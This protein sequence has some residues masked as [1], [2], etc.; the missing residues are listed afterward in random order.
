MVCTS[1][2]SYLASYPGSSQFFQWYTQKNNHWKTGR[3]LGTR[4]LLL[5]SQD[6]HTGIPYYKWNSPYTEILAFLFC[7][8]FTC[9]LYSI[10]H[11][12]CLFLSPHSQSRVPYKIFGLVGEKKKT[13]W[14]SRL[15]AGGGRRGVG[16]ISDMNLS[17]TL[18]SITGQTLYAWHTSTVL[19]FVCV[20]IYNKSDRSW[21]LDIL[22]I[23][24]CTVSAEF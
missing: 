12:L 8:L 24:C 23:L 19:E 9:I 5:L 22:R 4:L 1:S 2:A 14:S 21:H 13:F 7:A 20:W 17:Q 6:A 3:S 16:Y 18:Q 15:S 10:L 11:Q